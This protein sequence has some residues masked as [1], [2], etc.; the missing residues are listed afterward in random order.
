MI[1]RALFAAFACASAVALAGDGVRV[2]TSRSGTGVVVSVQASIRAP[3][4]VIWETL[5]D[6]DHLSEFVPGMKR[7][8]I[9]GRRG[10][11]VIVEQDGEA[12]L[13]FFTYPI[14]VVVEATERPPDMIMVNVLRGNLRQLE[15]RYQIE[16]GGSAD[17]HVLRWSGII[18]PDTVLPLFI[19]IPLM[20][21]SI[22]DQF[23]GM[24]REIERRSA[25]RPQR[26][27]PSGDR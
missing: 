7:S 24:V 16:Q 8:R 11:A 26:E 27:M 12:T 9:I 21:S 4:A 17:E 18:E 14:R 15:G 23:T 1:V 2:Q 20:R 3:R 22:E 6:Y 10:Q 25:A 19:T 5:T 13:L